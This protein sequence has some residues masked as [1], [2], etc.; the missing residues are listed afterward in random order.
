VKALVGLVPPL[1]T[2]WGNASL[3]DHDSHRIHRSKTGMWT[4]RPSFPTGRR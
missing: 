4:I 1:S 3:N 2:L